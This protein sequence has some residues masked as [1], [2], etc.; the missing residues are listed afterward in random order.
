MIK[1]VKKKSSSGVVLLALFN[2]A[3]GRKREEKGAGL[4][5]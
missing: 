2:T 5:S 3:V 1:N 4:H